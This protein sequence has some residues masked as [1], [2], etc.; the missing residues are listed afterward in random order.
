MILIINNKPQSVPEDVENIEQ[1]LKFLNVKR[2][3]TAVALNNKLILN[4]KWEST[5]LR[6]KDSVTLVTAAFGG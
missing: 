6:E 4:S 3:G 2:G 5:R 1:L